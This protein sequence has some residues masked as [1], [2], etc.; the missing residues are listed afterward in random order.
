[1]Q[2]IATPNRAVDLY[3]AGK[4]GFKNGNLA[5]GVAATEFEAAWCNGVQE[6]LLAV[7]EAAGLVPS[8]ATLN[9]LLLAMRAAGVFTTPAQFDNTTKAA[10]T[11]FVKARGNQAAGTTVVAV[12]GA[13]TVAHV[14]GMV[15]V[16]AAGATTQ[17][18]PAANAVPPGAEI[19]FINVNTG[20]ATVARAGAD[21]IT[22][23][24][25][26]VTSLALGAGDTLKLRSNGVSTWYA[27]A[28]S[29]QLA[30]ANQFAGSLG[31]PGWIKLPNGLILQ[32]LVVTVNASSVASFALPIGFPTAFLGALATMYGTTFSAG[33]N[34]GVGALPN[35]LGQVSVQNLYSASNMSVQ[36]LCLGN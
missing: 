20:V 9:Q 10:T 31:S 27:V 3:G 13:L 12:T 21:T 15:A 16:N 1:M 2:R 26:T 22:V 7:I 14:G 33:F 35:G 5:G 6:E 24:N 32:N 8:G 29:A 11:A 28:G 36:L 25:T 4:H 18:M 23:N 30:Y 17:T 19:E 34:A